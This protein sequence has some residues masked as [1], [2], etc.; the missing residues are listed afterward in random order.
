M[1]NSWILPPLDPCLS[2]GEVDIWRIELDQAVG[3]I[4]ELRMILASEEEARAARFHSPVHR[5]RFIVGRGSMRLILGRY[6]GRLAESLNFEAGPQGKPSLARPSRDSW[7]E[8]NLSHSQGLAVLAVTLGRRVGVDL[9][10][11]RPV[12]DIERL[13]A[14]FFSPSE[15]TA[16]LNVAPERRLSAFFRAWTRKE[17]YIKAIGTGLATSLESFDVGVDRHSPP[18]LLRVA[19]QPDE[20]GRWT[21]LDFD[22]GAAFLGSLVVEGPVSHLRHYAADPASMASVR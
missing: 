5:D 18:G 21:M 14:R 19:D 8:F 2:H 11:L 16:F 17:A 7:P 13:V 1:R 20:P 12:P 22:P 4:Q 9:E 6:L 3:V 10:A 15:R